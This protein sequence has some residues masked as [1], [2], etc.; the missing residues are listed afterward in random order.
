MGKGDFKLTTKHYRSRNFLTGIPQWYQNT[1]F[2]IN[3]ERLHKINQKQDQ[4][5]TGSAG[6]KIHS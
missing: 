3:Y 4:L 5:H 2:C 6:D 1:T